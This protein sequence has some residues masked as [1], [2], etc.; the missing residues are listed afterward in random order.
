[1]VSSAYQCMGSAGTRPK[2]LAQLPIYI[3]GDA[4]GP[5]P[6]T[7]G[8]CPERATAENCSGP[9]IFVKRF[10]GNEICHFRQ[11]A[12]SESLKSRSSA[13]IRFFDVTSFEELFVTPPWTFVGWGFTCE[14]GLE[15]EFKELRGPPG[16]QLSDFLL[17]GTSRLLLGG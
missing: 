5:S 13:K 4:G 15:W 17:V 7:P 9:D 3:V 6:G 12:L 2:S 11:F 1:M 16:C 14:S 8:G 10:V